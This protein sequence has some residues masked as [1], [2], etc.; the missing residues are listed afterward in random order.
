MK[1]KKFLLISILLTMSFSVV[2]AKQDYQ[3]EP[4]ETAIVNIPSIQPITQNVNT[5]E[6]IANVTENLAAELPE[7]VV[8]NI[9]QEDILQNNHDNMYNEEDDS[10]YNAEEID[11]MD[12]QESLEETIRENYR[13]IYGDNLPDYAEQEMNAEIYESRL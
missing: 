12:E 3:K 2:S 6:E 4:N 9:I 11:S 10:Y 13:A 8:Q 5:I 1:K 7:E